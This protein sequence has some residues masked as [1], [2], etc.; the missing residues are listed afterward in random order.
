MLKLSN[1]WANWSIFIISIDSL[2][3]KNKKFGKFLN[4]SVKNNDIESYDFL[5]K[6]LDLF[7]ADKEFRYFFDGY[8][9]DV[10]DLLAESLKDKSNR[11]AILN[12]LIQELSGQLMDGNGISFSELGV[13]VNNLQS[14][15][16]EYKITNNEK[17]KSVAL[18]WIDSLTTF[19]Q[20]AAFAQDVSHLALPHKLDVYSS[21]VFNKY[22]D[23]ESE[24][25]IARF[26]S[27]TEKEVILI[28]KNYEYDLA[29]SELNSTVTVGIYAPPIWLDEFTKIYN[30]VKFQQMLENVIGLVDVDWTSLKTSKIT[31]LY[32]T[33]VKADKLTATE[34]E[35]LNYVSDRIETHL[36]EIIDSTEEVLQDIDVID[37]NFPDFTNFVK[38]NGS[39]LRN[40]IIKNSDGKNIKGDLIFYERVPELVFKGKI[41][42]GKNYE[43]K[44]QTVEQAQ[45]LFD[46]R[47]NKIDDDALDARAYFLEKFGDKYWKETKKSAILQYMKDN[48]ISNG[49]NPSEEER[50]KFTNLC[51]MMPGKD[52]SI[53]WSWLNKYVSFRNIE[54]SEEDIDSRMSAETEGYVGMFSGDL[55]TVIKLTAIIDGK[56]FQTITNKSYDTNGFW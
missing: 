27:L 36:E 51:A 43:E 30:S 25:D 28:C 55:V 19:E 41:K 20:F 16:A 18:E 34:F 23:G 47:L 29:L 40:I 37:E 49:D 13:H 24:T 44:M 39:S 42:G 7:I 6:I 17:D 9:E 26:Y 21:D 54:I 12:K 48:R 46:S 22:N 31:W 2:G 8:T 50:I 33:L 53:F 3:P 10:A 56:K 11:I 5:N 45:A 32:N 15:I 52:I 4:T 38:Q 14:W 35:D 1:I